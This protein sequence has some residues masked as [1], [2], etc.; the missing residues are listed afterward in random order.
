MGTMA[1]ASGKNAAF[2]TSGDG[3]VVAAG[4]ASLATCLAAPP[5][6]ICGGLVVSMLEGVMTCSVDSAK[7]MR[8]PSKSRIATKCSRKTPP[9]THKSSSK[10]SPAEPMTGSC[11]ASGR[12]KI[13][14]KRR[15]AAATSWPSHFVTLLLNFPACHTSLLLH[16]EPSGRLCIT[17]ST[18][19]P[20]GTGGVHNIA[21]GGDLNGRTGGLPEELPSGRSSASLLLPK[22]SPRRSSGS[23]V[24]IGFCWICRRQSSPSAVGI[25]LK[26]SANSRTKARPPK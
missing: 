24:L 23:A 7:P 9:S 5:T 22:R 20:R 18:S 10:S 21:C 13:T 2:G 3:E 15:A 25:R 17:S 19:S 6:W 16:T 8:P 1:S 4:S 26:R 14:C 12:G 11:A